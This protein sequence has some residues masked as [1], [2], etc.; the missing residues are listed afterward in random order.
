[1]FMLEPDLLAMYCKAHSLFVHTHTHTHTYIY[2]YNVFSLLFMRVI[3]LPPV[4]W[5]MVYIILL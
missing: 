2:I 3:L 4:S 1:M 5:R